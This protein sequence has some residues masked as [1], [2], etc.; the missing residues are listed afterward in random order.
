MCVCEMWIK[1]FIEIVVNRNRKQR[2][3]IA[4]LCIGLTGI[5]I[6]TPYVKRFTPQEQEEEEKEEGEEKVKQEK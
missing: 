4:I 6:N 1:F 5:K 2:V 3:T